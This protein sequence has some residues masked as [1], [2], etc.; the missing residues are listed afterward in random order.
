MIT[1]TNECVDCGFPCKGNACPYRNVKRYYCDRCK[2][3]TTT[4]HWEDEH[5]CLDCIEKDL[6]GV[7]GNE[8]F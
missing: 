4:Y 1:V 2:E 3:E 8:D 5:V 7:E 6:I